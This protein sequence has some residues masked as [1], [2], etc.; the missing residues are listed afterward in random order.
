[1]RDAIEHCNDEPF[2]YGFF[3]CATF[4]AR[5][6]EAETGRNFLADYP[7]YQGVSEATTVSNSFGGLEGMIDHSLPRT[8]RA[9]SGDVVLIELAGIKALGICV[10]N[11]CAVPSREGGI[12]YVRRDRIAA[13]WKV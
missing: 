5:V 2:A 11:R 10:G 6:V 12:G 1:M 7:R 13:A 4:I 3:D 9:K 8:L